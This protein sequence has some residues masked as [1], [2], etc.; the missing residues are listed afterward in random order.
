MD[1]VDEDIENC[2]TGSK[3]VGARKLNRRKVVEGKVDY[4][5]S[6][7]YL[8]TIEGRILPK[9]VSIY[10]TPREPRDSYRNAV[11][12]GQKRKTPI[13]PG[14][15]RQNHKMCMMNYIPGQDQGNA[16]MLRNNTQKN[17]CREQGHIPSTSGIGNSQNQNKEYIKSMSIN[18]WKMA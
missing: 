6:G 15:G 14:Y 9:T 13:S 5:P 11:V 16:I 18:G 7:S 1:I 12:S 10:D 8:I 3:V 17:L 4:V 2:Q